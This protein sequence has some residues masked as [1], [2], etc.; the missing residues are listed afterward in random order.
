MDEENKDFFAGLFAGF[1]ITLLIVFCFV[2]ATGNF[3]DDVRQ[4]M[5]KD[6]AH[7]KQVIVVN[8]WSD[9]TETV[10]IRESGWKPNSV[11]VEKIIIAAPPQAK[12]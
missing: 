12:Q 11:V 9:G 3:P 10:F 6:I 1:V 2:G 5:A 4:S 8:K 7:G